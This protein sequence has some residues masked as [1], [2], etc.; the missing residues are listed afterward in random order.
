MQLALNEIMSAVQITSVTACRVDRLPMRSSAPGRPMRFWQHVH[1]LL[2]LCW[3]TAPSRL[4]E[5]ALSL[6]LRLCMLW[7]QQQLVK[8][9]KVLKSAHQACYSTWWVTRHCCCSPAW[10]R[11]LPKWLY[12]QEQVA[13][14][15]PSRML[16]PL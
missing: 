1:C 3:W 6:A 12:L 16:S 5:A 10:L 13:P 4:G 11:G 9:L 2:M 14:D 15:S 8:S 7:G